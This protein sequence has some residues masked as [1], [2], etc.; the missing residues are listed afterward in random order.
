M[1]LVLLSTVFAA[2]CDDDASSRACLDAALEHALSGDPVAATELK[3]SCDAG[4][5]EACFHRGLYALVLGKDQEFEVHD[6]AREALIGRC[7]SSVGAACYHLAVLHERGPM[8]WRD[9]SQASMY[10]RQA[11]GAGEPRG[12]YA[13]ASAYAA[14][15]SESAVAKAR[16]LYDGACYQQK[17]AASCVA[18]GEL[19]AASD[20]SASA[21]ALERACDLGTKAACK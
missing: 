17:H 2:P 9:G 20:P 13:Q 10:N 11:C 21:A 3:S 16:E 19:V 18:L 8:D 4:N 7:K 5:T 6:G 1:F 12:C 15:G 14:G